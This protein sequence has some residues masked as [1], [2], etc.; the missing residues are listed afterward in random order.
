MF[1]TKASLT[2]RGQQPSCLR[3]TK[4]QVISTS[5]Q[6]CFY[7]DCAMRVTA[8]LVD[9]TVADIRCV[10]KSRCLGEETHWRWSARTCPPGRTCECTERGSETRSIRNLPNCYCRLRQLRQLAPFMRSEPPVCAMSATAMHTSTGGVTSASAAWWPT[11]CTA[12][13]SWWRVLVAAGA[14]VRCSLQGCAP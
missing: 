4:H 10:L 14:R 12:E 5:H 8:E 1:R 7:L 11:S 9:S 2:R 3:T 13:A 6:V